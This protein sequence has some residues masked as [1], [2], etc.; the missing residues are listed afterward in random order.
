MVLPVVISCSGGKDCSG[1]AMGRYAMHILVL[2]IP[3]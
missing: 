1:G 3:C 2:K